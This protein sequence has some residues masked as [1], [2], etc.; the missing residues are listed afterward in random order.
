MSINQMGDE[1][2]VLS[3]V[4]L[5]VDVRKDIVREVDHNSLEFEM[6]CSTP[7]QDHIEQEHLLIQGVL[8]RDEGMFRSGFY[9][10]VRILVSF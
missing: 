7:R 4:P 9:I 5:V 2:E 3:I 1:E 10:N 6:E 8:D